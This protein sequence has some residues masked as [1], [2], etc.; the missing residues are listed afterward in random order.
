MS[1]PEGTMEPQTHVQISTN[2]THAIEAYGR[3]LPQV[4]RTGVRNMTG[5]HKALLESLPLNAYAPKFS[6][7]IDEGQK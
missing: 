1:W 5:I 6:T 4:L 2:K 7:L 3:A